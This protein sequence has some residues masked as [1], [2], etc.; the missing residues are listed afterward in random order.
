MKLLTNILGVVS[1]TAIAVTAQA[2]DPQQTSDIEITKAQPSGP[3]SESKAGTDC[4]KKCVSPLSQETEAEWN[5]AMFCLERCELDKE[6]AVYLGYDDM[7]RKLATPLSATPNSYGREA[8]GKDGQ[9]F[10]LHREF[11]DADSLLA[12]EEKLEKTAW[13]DESDSN[14][15]YRHVLEDIENLNRQFTLCT[16]DEAEGLGRKGNSE[17]DVKRTAALGDG[18]FESLPANEGTDA[19]S[20]G[21]ILDRDSD[22]PSAD[23]DEDEDAE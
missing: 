1:C 9:G 2:P 12:F 6:A 4:A 13:F 17:E 7:L 20:Y 21:D 15:Q 10:E 16:T 22:S 5:I 18:P 14:N 8:Y 23:E 3:V 19:P 11:L